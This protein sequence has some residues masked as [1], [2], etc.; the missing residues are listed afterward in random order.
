MEGIVIIFPLRRIE[1]GAGWNNFQQ[2]YKRNT[3]HFISCNSN[4]M[5][6]DIRM[7][8]QV[9]I[10][11]S[12]VCIYV[13]YVIYRLCGMVCIIVLHANVQIT[14]KDFHPFDLNSFALTDP[15]QFQIESHIASNLPLRS[16]TC[17]R[18][19]FQPVIKLS[20]LLQRTLSKIWKNDY[21]RCSISFRPILK[22][23][24]QHANWYQLGFETIGYL[25]FALF[26]DVM[27]CF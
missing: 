6:I 5:A 2:T 27:S 17:P 9:Y 15:L 18:G 16:Y 24:S 22:L 21:L 26:A 20:V 4:V 11:N 23:A 3:I 13:T 10:L 12:K 19:K 14:S 8:V 1:C 7:Q 25:K